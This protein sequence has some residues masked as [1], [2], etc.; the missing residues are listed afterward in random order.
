MVWSSI[1]TGGVILTPQF[2]CAPVSHVPLNF[3]N[4]NGNKEIFCNP[5]FAII[6]VY[7]YIFCVLIVLFT[8]LLKISSSRL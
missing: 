2:C 6:I 4:I 8:A 7:C 1:N 5:Y 3:V